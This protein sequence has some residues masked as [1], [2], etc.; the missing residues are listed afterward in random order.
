MN[1]CTEELAWAAT[2]VQWTTGPAVTW[3]GSSRRSRPAPNS[4]CVL[5]AGRPADLDVQVGIAGARRSDDELAVDERSE[6]SRPA[7][8]VRKHR[9]R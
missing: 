6:G 2:T 5:L 4:I 9:R 8:A 3:T 7:V 1:T